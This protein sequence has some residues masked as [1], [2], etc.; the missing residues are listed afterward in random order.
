MTSTVF[1]DKT[2][3]IEASWLN[4]VDALVYQ[5]QLDDGTTGA[6]ISQYLP[7]GTGAV[8]TTVQA[9]LRER[10]SVKDFGAVG[11]GVT[12]DTAAILKAFTHAST[13]INPIVYFPAGTYAVTSSATVQFE[14]TEGMEV[15]GDGMAASIIKWTAQNPGTTIC[16]IGR[17]TSATQ[18]NFASIRDLAV[19]GDHDTSGYVSNSSY[20]FLIYKCSSLHIDS[21]KVTHS[22]MMSIVTR[23][24]Y[25]VDVSNCIVQ[26]GARDGI[27]T[28][29]CN[30]VKITNNRVEYV[31]DDAIAVHT[32]TS[33]V[34]D[35]NCVISNNT[36]R[37]SQGIKALGQR[38]TTISSNS[39]EYC[40]GQG[41]S[42]DAIPATIPDQSG[43][44][45]IMG[46]VITGNSIKN[47]FDR[48][49]IDNLNQGAP[50]ITVNSSSA[51][52]GTLTV[53][54]GTPDP[55]TGITV[56][57]YPYY[58]TP[59]NS[60]MTQPVADSINVLISNNILVRDMYPT[61]AIS[62][63]GFGSFY[64]RTG[65]VDPAVTESAY[66]VTGIELGGRLK[67]IN[68][69][70]NM[71]AGIYA[72]ISL[73]GSA[74]IYSTNISSNYVFDC[75]IG[76]SV[77]GSN[78]RTHEIHVNKNTFDLDPY[79]TSTLRGASGTY[80]AQGLLTVLFIQNSY[81][82]TFDQNTIK[83]TS[84]V[85]DYDIGSTSVGQSARVSS[86]NGNNIY[87]DPVSIGFSTSNK[88]VGNIPYGSLI[89]VFDCNPNSATYNTIKN[90]CP[91]QGDTIPTAGTYIRGH[92]VKK[93]NAVVAGTGPNQYVVTG[94]VRLT[95]GSA[96]VLNTDWAEMRTLTG[97]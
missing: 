39:L 46:V 74:E 94:W 93:N 58:Y 53:I 24:C 28:A 20:P 49:Y 27:N 21:V 14:L 43:S 17:P 8:A 2:T 83:N 3:L 73:R 33:S 10:V 92:I 61:A 84:R 95:T 6:S 63:Y 78:T 97:T 45:A 25:S 29:D 80:T 65:P 31:D 60:S 59:N 4:D 51:V 88:G 48:Q 72:G 70:N 11:D 12:D 69:S 64:M 85:C 44:T 96:H 91:L 57:P 36:I 62:D 50:Y 81:G 66:R 13:Q 26:Y 35:R 54:P 89:T 90:F 34:A 5:G 15:V 7:A 42:V 38:S 40:F 9:K 30:F 86:F 41:I 82:F 56:S 18:I 32:T 68:I 71:L 1:V 47:N 22:R 79:F 76:I 77:D 52:P 87:C 55:A 23:A 16:L 67:N 19:R 75:K 37:F